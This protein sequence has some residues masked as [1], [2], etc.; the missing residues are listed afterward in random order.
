MVLRWHL[1]REM[2]QEFINGCVTQNK[3]P[4]ATWNG[5]VS[6]LDTYEEALAEEGSDLCLLVLVLSQ[7]IVL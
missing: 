7:T 2:V 4:V 3:L 5:L 1:P 6:D